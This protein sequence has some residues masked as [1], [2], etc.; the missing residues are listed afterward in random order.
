[1]NYQPALPE[2]IKTIQLGT[3]VAWLRNLRQVK[4]HLAK[5]PADAFLD[6]AI[7]VLVEANGDPP[8]NDVQWAAW[9]MRLM[10]K[11]G[12]PQESKDELMAL[13][14]GLR[15]GVGGL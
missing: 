2:V 7:Q 9:A 6:W 8:S 1:M 12:Y 10:E 13:I 14:T 4:E 15:G 5:M 3:L 11:H